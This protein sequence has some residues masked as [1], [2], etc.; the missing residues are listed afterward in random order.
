MPGPLQ[1]LLN[2]RL[3]QV[4][5]GTRYVWKALEGRK[6]SSCGVL[7]GRGHRGPARGW[8]CSALISCHIKGGKGFVWGGFEGRDVS[9]SMGPCA[10][11]P[12]HT[13]KSPHFPLRRYLLR[14]TN[15]Q[16]KPRGGGTTAKSVIP[17]TFSYWRDPGD[18]CSRAC[19]LNERTLFNMPVGS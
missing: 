5:P 18:L 16:P 3:L 19:F 15:K 12:L 1:D 4:W 8:S 17:A 9:Q 2:Q 14:Q 11:I 6:S 7:T 10:P 13:L